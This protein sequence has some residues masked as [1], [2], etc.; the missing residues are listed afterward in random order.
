MLIK[1][2]VLCYCVLMY[3]I[4]FVI[5]LT[6]H[7]AAIFCDVW[8]ICVMLVVA[9]AFSPLQCEMVKSKHE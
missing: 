6:L 7:T 9:V 3:N 2:L 5:T 1:L 8:K 4:Y